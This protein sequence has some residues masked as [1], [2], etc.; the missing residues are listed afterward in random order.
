M[1]N[2]NI[3]ANLAATFLCPL[4]PAVAVGEECRRL[5]E[6]QP[7]ENPRTGQDSTPCSASASEGTT[8]ADDLS[9]FRQLV[10]PAV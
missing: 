3:L 7:E 10:I 6:R 4:A 2:K 9:L 1:K 8:G 5:R